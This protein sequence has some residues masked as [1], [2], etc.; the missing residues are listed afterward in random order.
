MHRARRTTRSAAL[1]LLSFA[2]ITPLSAQTWKLTTGGDWGNQNNWQ[3]PAAVPNNGAAT[4][5]PTGIT[6]NAGINIGQLY[7]VNRIDLTNDNTQFAYTLQSS[8]AAG[9]LKFV[10]NM[11][12]VQVG[13]DNAAANTL[14]V[15]LQIDT[16]VGLTF[17]NN[18]TA[19]LTVSSVI[20]GN[21]VGSLVFTVGPVLL[22]GSS[23][24]VGVSDIRSAQVSITKNAALG[25]NSSPIEI[26]FGGLLRGVGAN[27][28]LSAARTIKPQSFG[29]A[30]DFIFA[31]DDTNANNIF[32]V[33]AKII[34]LNNNRPNMGI[35]DGVRLT[36]AANDFI[37]RDLIQVG[38]STVDGRLYLSNDG[39]L[40][41][42]A[43]KISIV[44]GKI[45]A[46][47][48][49]TSAREFTF[50][51]IGVFDV[52]ADKTLTLSGNI[53]AGQRLTKQ[54]PGALVLGGTNN[55]TLSTRIDGGTLAVS[56][57]TNLGKAGASIVMATGATL[58]SDDA[59]TTPRAITL[60][61]GAGSTIDVVQPGQQLK[62]FQV[63]GLVG[64]GELIKRGKGNLN[65][66]NTKNSFDSSRV[67]DGGLVVDNDASLGKAA[68]AVTLGGAGFLFAT[69]SFDSDR[70]IK[71]LTGTSN[72]GA[73]VKVGKT[74]KLSSGINGPNNFTKYNPGNL[75]LTKDSTSSIGLSAFIQDGILDINGDFKTG[76]GLFS[77]KGT[78]LEGGGTISGR[79]NNK[80][81]VKPGNSPGTLTVDGPVEFEP[82]SSIQIDMNMATGA[83][84]SELGWGLLDVSGLFQTTGPV[85]VE[86]NSLLTSGDP[87]LVPDFN[88]NQSYRWE[89]L[90]SATAISGFQPFEW[91]VD[92]SGFLNS[93]H[94]NFS[95][96]VEQDGSSL[97]IDYA[98]VPE[99]SGLLLGLVT[100]ASGIFCRLRLSVKT[101]GCHK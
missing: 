53:V 31:G 57:D 87:G 55:Y 100:I 35:L 22:S 7:T 84:G 94:P 98:A 88:P 27:A 67:M 93:T 52:L 54:G 59:F 41:N 77:S 79:F 24:Y 95:F 71:L 48:T 16:N 86:L 81:K 10:G 74:L 42:A 26:A 64:G 78:K 3:N 75:V 6:A 50:S 43:N 13:A 80:G 97:Y 11:P 12:H 47:D 73:A 60:G 8:A 25:D 76:K 34:K 37:S 17:L 99:P 39:A 69:D 66:T 63:D 32:Q 92:A 45:I 82:E 65:L 61:A 101:I 4:V 70:P 33:D 40:G 83:A 28:S 56:A 68:G 20:S 89:F 15:P 90:R 1:L 29:D 44:R 23:T 30:I 85:V 91:T 36:N 58:R 72:V 96:S 19:P 14:S 62:T 49:F 18:S 2:A 21:N 5:F 38:S 46:E 9:A 51:S